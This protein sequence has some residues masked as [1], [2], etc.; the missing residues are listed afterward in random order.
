MHINGLALPTT[1]GLPMADIDRGFVTS[2]G[3]RQAKLYTSFA[4]ICEGIVTKKPSH[5]ETRIVLF[6][7]LPSSYTTE[8]ILV[9][10]AFLSHQDC[11]KCTNFYSMVV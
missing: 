3:R 6:S 2:D 11:A 1:Q 4:T 10:V 5:N 9:Y 7:D 8:V